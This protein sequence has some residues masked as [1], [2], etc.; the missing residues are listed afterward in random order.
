MGQN[1]M[2]RMASPLEMSAVCRCRIRRI[3]E[4]IHTDQVSNRLLSSFLK[5]TLTVPPTFF[6]GLEA[7][8]PSIFVLSNTNLFSFIFYPSLETH[9]INK[10]PDFAKSF[11]KE[12]VTT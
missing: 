7:S 8:A 1:S 5:Q 9:G 4:Q 2:T 12:V 11:L 6:S 10:Q 3:P